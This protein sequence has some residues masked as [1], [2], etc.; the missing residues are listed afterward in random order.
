[1]LKFCTYKIINKNNNRFLIGST[2]NPKIRER[3]HFMALQNNRH[4]NTNFQNS[5]NKHGKS[6][7]EFVILDE[8]SDRKS[9]YLAEQKI[10]DRYYGEYECYNE[11]PAAFGSLPGKKHPL[12]GIKRPDVSKRNYKGKVI[13][14]RNKYTNDIIEER[15]LLNM[16]NRLG[17]LIQNLQSMVKGYRKSVKGWE[18]YNGKC[19][20]N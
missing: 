14:L 16:A 11:S 13:K 18:V 20:F 7:F 9:A 12:F 8:Y 15:G 4:W 6:S 2:G 1:M 10:L 19:N 17:I 5:Y 3:Q